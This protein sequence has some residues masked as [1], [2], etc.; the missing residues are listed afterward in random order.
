MLRFKDI[1]LKEGSITTLI[2][3]SDRTHQIPL[4]NTLV[5]DIKGMVISNSPIFPSLYS[6][7]NRKRNDNLAKPRKHM[8]KALRAHNRLKAGLHSFR[9]TF[10]C[11]LRDKG[12]NIDDRRQL[13][14][15]SSSETTRIYTHPNFDLAKN[16]IN[17]IPDYSSVTQ[18]RD[19]NVT[20]T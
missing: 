14:A 5:K 19:Q 3:K 4:S 11:I 9:V 1:D 18:K 2:R 20:K 7:S 6:E 13:L 8:Q 10:N 17:Q 16:Y 15:H 12:L